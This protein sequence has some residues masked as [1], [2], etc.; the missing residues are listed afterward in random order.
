MYYINPDLFYLHCLHSKIYLKKFDGNNNFRQH[1]QA[2]NCGM[3][4][5]IQV[6]V[7]SEVSGVMFT[8]HPTTQNPSQILITASY[9]LGEVIFLTQNLF[10]CTLT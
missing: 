5:V 8:C 6:M 2:V 1:G 7:P 4:V 3:G 10:T 9:G